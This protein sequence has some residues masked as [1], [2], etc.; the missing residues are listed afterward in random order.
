MDHSDEG[1]LV[2]ATV[3][4]TL[5]TTRFRSSLLTVLLLI[6]AGAVLFGVVRILLPP[7]VR[8][9]E[10]QFDFRIA[11]ARGGFPIVGAIVNL[12]PEGEYQGISPATVTD[13]S[14]QGQLIATIWSRI[15]RETSS[16]GWGDRECLRRT[17]QQTRRPPLAR[18][19]LLFTAMIQ[20]QSAAR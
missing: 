17:S 18:L 12:S 14:G 16:P 19:V 2:G 7:A 8:Y 6:A 11:D 4:S 3:H 10:L 20:C 9:T 13:S 1:H 15:R 5:L